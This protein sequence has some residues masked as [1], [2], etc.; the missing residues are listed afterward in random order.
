MT[1][2]GYRLL[3]LL[4]F[5]FH[6][7]L[8]VFN[9]V[10]WAWRRTRR[11]HLFTI[12]GTIFS[13]FGFGAVYGWGYCPLTDWHWRVKEALGQTELPAS[14]LKYY[15]DRATGLAWDPAV[16]DTL[17]VTPALAALG[18]S[19]W[20]NLRDLRGQGM[21]RQPPFGQRRGSP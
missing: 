3:D 4:L 15:L 1:D 16:V 11:L 19:V 9:V 13:W 21:R 12:C 10:G 2:P 14:W 7:A 5:G 20:L 6:A 17:V 18:L 8:V